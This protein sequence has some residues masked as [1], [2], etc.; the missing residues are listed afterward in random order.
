M[1]R[2]KERA[3]EKTNT[4][5]HNCEKDKKPKKRRRQRGKK[6][7]DKKTKRQCVQNIAD[8][9]YQMLTCFLAGPKQPDCHRIGRCN[10][11]LDNY[12]ALQQVLAEPDKVPTPL[13]QYFLSSIIC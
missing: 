5:K 12:W 13:L 8:T 1:S 9:F 6:T 3:K 7:K 4:Q 2:Q 10:S 11:S